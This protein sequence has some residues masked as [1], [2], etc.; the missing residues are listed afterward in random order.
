[1]QGAQQKGTFHLPV[2]AHWG[3]VTL[4]PGDYFV[5]L[6]DLSLGERTFRVTG[7]GKTILEM[8]IAIDLQKESKT[9]QLEL[10]QIEGNYFVRG[11]SSAAAGETFTFSVPKRHPTEEVAKLRISRSNPRPELALIRNCRSHPRRPACR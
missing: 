6:P 3:S 8:P 10:W 5:T 7:D 1:M 4:Q 9:S 11:F 2:A